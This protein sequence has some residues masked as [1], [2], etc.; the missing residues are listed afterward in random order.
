MDMRAL[1]SLILWLASACLCSSHSQQMNEGYMG[2][3]NGQAQNRL[4][5]ANT[6]H[7]RDHLKEHLDKSANVDFDKMSERE[8]SFHYFK[9]HDLDMNNKLDGLELLQAFLH[10]Y[11]ENVEDKGTEEDRRKARETREDMAIATLDLTLAEF[12]ANDD[13]Y[14]DYVEF[15]NSIDRHLENSKPNKSQ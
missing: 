3:K 5:D 1:S 11:E 10:G 8:V 7:D 15:G 2:S 14:I 12:D 13:G 4:K 9:V 6:V